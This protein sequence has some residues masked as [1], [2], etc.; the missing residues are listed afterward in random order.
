MRP[1]GFQIVHKKLASLF[2][3]IEIIIKSR[4]EPKKF[5]GPGVVHLI[6]TIHRKSENMKRP[7]RESKET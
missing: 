7:E 6:K 5:V 2:H 3:N 4:D 1:V